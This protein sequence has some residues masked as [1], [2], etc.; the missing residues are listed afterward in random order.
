MKTIVII[1]HRYHYHISQVAIL[2]VVKNFNPDRIAILFDDV[3]G[4]QCGWDKLGLKLVRDIKKIH[5]FEPGSIFSVPF[6]SLNGIHNEPEGWIR[7][8][9]VKLNLHKLLPDNEWLVIDG[10]VLINTDIDPWRY[11][12]INPG[13]ELKL[14]HDWFVRY[15][16]NLGDKRVYYNNNPVE[17]SSVPIRLLTRKMLED[18]EKH[19][20]QLHNTDIKGVRDSFTLKQNR[21]KY[22]ELSEYDL[23]GNYQHFISM[24]SLP[25]KE[26]EIYFNPKDK[27]FSNWN[28]L[29]DKVAV[30]HG[31]D[32]LPIEW[33]Q[34][35]GVN[36]N[37][38]I[39]DLLYSSQKINCNSN[40]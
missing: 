38:E 9:Y 15:T 23:I 34:Q 39:W 24:D 30:L 5:E 21:S 3:P 6:S 2:L 27:L 7:Q 11:C 22:L 35:F 17:F 10:D 31:W 26:L 28:F 36:I 32:N 14:H 12:Y 8:Q 19:I 16:L 25:L 18:F 29:K 33:Y 1:T 13:D 20:Y 40:E 4:T 37:Q